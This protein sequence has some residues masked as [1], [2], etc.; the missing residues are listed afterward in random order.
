MKK[1]QMMRGT[2]SSKRGRDD[3][4][5]PPTS[6]APPSTKKYKRKSDVTFNNNASSN[7]VE[8]AHP[9]EIQLDTYPASIE[10]QIKQS[11][12]PCDI[13]EVAEIP[14]EEPV[15]PIIPS[16]LDLHPLAVN[17]Y[18]V[19][20]YPR[21]NTNRL[22]KIIERTQ[23]MNEDWK[24]YVHY[25]D[26]NRRM[27]EWIPAERILCHPSIANP[28]GN[29]ANIIL[30]L[31]HQL[32]KQKQLQYQQL[33]SGNLT[34][35]TT[36]TAS[37]VA[38]TTTTTIAPNNTNTTT[39]T[40]STS[41]EK[42][43]TNKMKSLQRQGSSSSVNTTTST[44]T[45]TTTTV[46][47]PTIT[48]PTTKPPDDLP[49]ITP[50]TIQDAVKRL[51]ALLSDATGQSHDSNY[52]SIAELDH[53]EH[54]G[55]DED[56]ILAHERVTK[57]K[58][59]QSIQFGKYIMECWYFSPFPK[60]YYQPYGGYIDRLYFDEYTL[61]FF[62]TKTELLRYQQYSCSIPYPPGKEI[63]RDEELGLSMFEIDGAIERNYCQNLC[64]LAKLFLDHKT[65]YWDVESFLFYILCKREQPLEGRDGGDDFV[66]HQ[67]GYYHP[68]GYFSK[69]K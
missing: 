60:E 36:A 10:P 31:Q 47:E 57:M 1:G 9:S 65:L 14:K 54:E 3:I 30:E 64:Y 16:P 33:Q 35:N 15:V 58:N 6:Q 63:Y 32:Q 50:Q 22:A 49:L 4:D 38:T 13:I 12:T 46:S 37:T 68:V 66:A 51:S 56:S 55:L 26:F 40:T 28:I 19:V 44:T 42:G 41:S 62:K 5:S 8:A 11:E 20:K 67:L 52:T 23:D 7:D 18:L 61:R 39:C 34:N 69:E 25:F 27:D 45:N 59:I 53:D 24:Y 2:R 48:D 29:Q 17:D 21:D 43:V